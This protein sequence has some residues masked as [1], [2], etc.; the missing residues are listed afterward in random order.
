LRVFLA[1]RS[2]RAIANE[3]E[4]EAFLGGRGYVKV[5]PEDLDVAGQFRLFR[6]A[7]SMV[8]I[9][10][11]ALAP[12]L[13]QSRLPRLGE[14]VE[15]L[16]AGHMSDNFRVIAQQIGLPWVGVRG[17]IKPGYVRAAYDFDR[18]FGA[19]SVDAFEVD[20]VSLDRALGLVAGMR[21]AQKA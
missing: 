15:I 2:R 19:F 20:P 7:E 12:L 21:A 16:P 14:L 6:E 17:R 8:A 18:R 11:A 9:H 4:I 5:Y 10:G 13:Y 3:A 1:R